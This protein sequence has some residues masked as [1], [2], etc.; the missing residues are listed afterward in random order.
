ME[1]GDSDKDNNLEIEVGPIHHS[2]T[3]IPAGM[4]SDTAHQLPLPAR[5]RYARLRRSLGVGGLVI[6]LLL[7]LAVSLAP[8]RDA[9][10]AAI[11]GPTA[12]ATEPLRLG[13][14]NLYISLSPDW[15][16]VSLDGKTLSHLPV[17][18]VEQPLRLTRGSHLLHWV[19]E[20]V[21]DY[22]CRLSVPSVESDTCPIG[23]GIL[24]G[25][26]G[27]ASSVD[28][29]L[30]LLALKPNYAS[31]LANAIQAALDTHMSRDVIRTGERY[32]GARQLNG[33]VT[34][35]QPLN[36]T[37]HVVSD[38]GNE[39]ARCAAIQSGPG[40]NCTMNGDCREICTA[41][42]QTPQHVPANG[43]W[44][45]FIIAH[46]IWHITT[47]DGQVITPEQPDI[48]GQLQFLGQDEHPMP[49]GIGWNGVQWTVTAEF[50]GAAMT[51]TG[52]PA[53]STARD[54]VA[55]QPFNPPGD[56]N[57]QWFYL[58]GA[59]SALGC[60]AA[61]IPLD[62]QGTPVVGGIGQSLPALVLHR[63]GVALA[64]NA[65]AHDTWPFLPVADA[66]EQ[67]LAQSLY[68]RLG[69]LMSTSHVGGQP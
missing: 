35:Q 67:A 46:S 54:E 68:R 57:Y 52:D 40:E 24:P 31:A 47:P 41:P 44:Q 11:F 59:P 37:L 42:W 3:E 9:M 7:T 13:Q 36:A 64:A 62:T 21:I 34:A 25:K 69:K 17:E 60:L 19:Y 63:F 6:V 38:L 22:S 61:D 51:E 29:R 28:L 49:V 43:L 32:W 5:L 27:V 50:D 16:T 20:P 55:F 10:H 23:V 1:F 56:Q 39:N 30:S 18:G 45:A 2:R 4:S 8:T 15:G 66:Y 48:G 12:T 53:C 33:P 65:I 14:D 58:A 26:K